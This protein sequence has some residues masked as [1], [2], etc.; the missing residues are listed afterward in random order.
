MALKQTKRVAPESHTAALVYVNP[1]SQK[2][3]VTE[4]DENTTE[5]NKIY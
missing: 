3:R 2:E 1:Q 5:V 4:L